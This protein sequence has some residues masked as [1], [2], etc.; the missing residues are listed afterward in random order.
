[1][2]IGIIQVRQQGHSPIMPEVV[3]LLREWGAQVDSIYPEGTVSSLASIRVDHDLY[4][5][6]SGTELALSLA[7]VLDAAGAVILNSFPVATMM[8]D[9][10]AGT[11]ILQAAGLPVP[12]TYVGSDARQFE[13]LLDG[14]PLIFKPY[15][16]WQGRGIQVVR[17]ACEL[18]D[19]APSGGLVYAQRFH[20]PDGCDRKIYSIGGQLFGVMR[21]WPVCSFED[22]T[23]VP[24][25]LSPELHDL[26][27]RCGQAFGIDLFGIDVIESA[28]KA[29]VVDF[30]SFPGFKGVPDAALR[31]A[32]YIYTAAQRV[33]EGKPVMEPPNVRVAA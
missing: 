16:G 23:G 1:M 19:V 20:Q 33:L 21:K 15:R 9:K 10:I 5:L 28:G 8:R 3:Q 27:R 25:T 4:V 32:D 11:G 29:W 14:G 24:F 6:K 22:K 26:A 7:G 13:P 30:C 12:D 31:L 17:Q 2:K 18:D